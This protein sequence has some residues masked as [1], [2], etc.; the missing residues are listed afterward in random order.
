M[1]KVTLETLEKEHGTP[2]KLLEPQKTNVEE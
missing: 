2:V 1:T